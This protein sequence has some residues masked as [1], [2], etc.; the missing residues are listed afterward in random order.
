MVTLSGLPSLGNIH[1][2]LGVV[3]GFLILVTLVLGYS[4]RR[5]THA[6]NT[7][8]QGHRWLGRVVICLMALTMILG[9]FFLSLLLGR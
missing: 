2:I 9:I 3:T 8:R 4:I 7:V 5:I 6:K 1:E